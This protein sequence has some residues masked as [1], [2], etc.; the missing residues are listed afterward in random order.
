MKLSCE[1]HDNEKN[2]CQCSFEHTRG[3]SGRMGLETN[4]VG[5]LPADDRARAI[6]DLVRREGFQAI[7]V[8][9][10]R[11][12]VTTRRSVVTSTCCSTPASYPGAMA[13]PRCR[14]PAPPPP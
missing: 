14:P 8:L 11:F 12:G 10:G 1:S 2:G 9:A 5:M 4:G 7:E 3:Q 13:A 6:V